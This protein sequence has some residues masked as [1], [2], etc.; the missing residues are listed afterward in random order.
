MNKI[1]TKKISLKRYHAYLFALALVLVISALLT[2][3]WDGDSRDRADTVVEAIAL[4]DSG[5]QQDAILSLE[6]ICRDN[7]GDKEALSRL[8]MYYYQTREF[9]KFLDLTVDKNIESATIYNMMADVYSDR[10][11]YV[12]AERYFK[13]AIRTNP[14]SSS[15]YVSFA[16]Y[17]QKRADYDSSLATLEQGLQVLPNSSILLNSAASICLK[18]GDKVRANEYANAVLARDPENTQAEAILSETK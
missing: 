6:K 2:F 18:K 14:R 7:P 1:F 8:A 16:S 13:E 9:D 17:Y 4:F 11:D 3:L 12:N 5:K 10:N 15:A